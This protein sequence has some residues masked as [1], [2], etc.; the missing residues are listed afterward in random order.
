MNEVSLIILFAGDESVGISPA[1]W[2]IQA[3]GELDDHEHRQ[4]V[5]E[6]FRDAFGVLLGEQVTVYF[7][8]ELDLIT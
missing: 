3:I 1:S 7:S 4:E 2:E 6:A 8:D 5:R